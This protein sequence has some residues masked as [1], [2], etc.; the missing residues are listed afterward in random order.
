MNYLSYLVT[1]M[2]V[3]FA[4]QSPPPEEHSEV[5]H[6]H[7]PARYTTE[8]PEIDAAK[9][10]MEA[11][12]AGDWNKFRAGYAD[13]AE[14]FHNSNEPIAPDQLL[15]NTKEGL[16]A[17]SSYTFTDEQYWERII[18]DEGETWVYFWGTWQA[19]HASS[20]TKFEIPVH[21]AWHH[22]DGKVVEEYGLWDRTQIVLAEMGSAQ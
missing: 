13:D 18:D 8:A 2:L 17:V 4:C 7:G 12:L 10:G 14:I 9:A 19:D 6:D 15:E 16:E 3:T 11:Y 20:E 21:L 1:I 5:P 22:K